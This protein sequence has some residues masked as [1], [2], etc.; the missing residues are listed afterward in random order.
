MSIDNDKN[1]KMSSEIYIKK[2]DN[3]TKLKLIAK[4]VCGHKET[5]ILSQSKQE[6]L[7]VG[8][9][10]SSNFPWTNWSIKSIDLS[11]YYEIL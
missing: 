6:W 4:I 3:T 8:N 5:S 2:E 10:Y 1:T 7:G 11:M 9:Y